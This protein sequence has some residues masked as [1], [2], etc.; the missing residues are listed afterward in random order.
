VP[1]ADPDWL[2]VEEGFNPVRERE[3]ESLFAIANGYVGTRGSLAEGSRYSSPATYLAGVFDV[4]PE[5]GDTPELAVAPDWTR[6]LITVEGNPLELEAGEALEHRR[7]LDLR[8]GILWRDWRHRDLAGR[9]TRLRFVRLVSLADRHALLQSV[10]L[11][12][13]NYSGR[14]RIE[15]VID[16][17][18][19]REASAVIEAMHGPQPSV[20]SGPPRQTAP[21]SGPPVVVELRTASGVTIALAVSSRLA[22]GAVEQVPRAI[23]AGAAR[24]VELGAARA[25]ELGAARAVE[26]WDWEAEIGHTY[27]LLRLVSVHTSRDAERPSEAALRRGSCAGARGPSPGPTPGPGRLAGRQP[28]CRSMATTRRALR[29]AS[30]AITCRARPTPPTSGPRLARGP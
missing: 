18:P 4:G 30:P 19:A 26:A 20:P 27:R 2:L 12:P 8:Q 17:A 14:L 15:A 25:V 9:V 13:E 1:T 16:A 24:A 28:T 11:T 10:T 21:E 22:T 23:E 5:P 29:C 6:L 3:V 7:V